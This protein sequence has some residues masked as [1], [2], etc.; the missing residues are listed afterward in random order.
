MAIVQVIFVLSSLN[1]ELFFCFC[2]LFML[3]RRM[4]WSPMSGGAIKAFCLANY[5]QTSSPGH[6]NGTICPSVHCAA[7]L[8][9]PRVP[10]RWGPHFCR[11]T[12]DLREFM[13]DCR[14]CLFLPLWVFL[15]IAL[16]WV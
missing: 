10:S 3:F 15:S 7:L 11:V 13:S 4:M 2:F 14:G 12:V 1:T 8:F 6:P 9:F 16:M 5:P